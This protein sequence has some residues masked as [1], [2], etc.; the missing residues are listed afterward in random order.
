[1]EFSLHAKHAPEPMVSLYSVSLQAVQLPPS[2]PEY[3]LLHVQSS[4]WSLNPTAPE[5][6]GQSKHVRLP[7]ASEYE[8]IAQTSQLFW[9]LP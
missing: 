5:F 1:M 8:F 6:E 4:F 3:P 7:G 9:L 2:G